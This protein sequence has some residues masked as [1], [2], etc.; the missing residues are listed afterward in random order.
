MSAVRVRTNPDAPT[1]EIEVLADYLV[2]EPRSAARALALP[3][4]SAS[5][6]PT[7]PTIPPL[8]AA[9]ANAPARWQ[10]ELDR[11]TREHSE[12]RAHAAELEIVLARRS[13]E[14]LEA[15][16]REAVLVRRF[17]LQT[18]RIAD[19]DR[20][21]REQKTLIEQLQ[22]ALPKRPSEASE[23]L[24]IRGIGPKYARNLSA[25][26]VSTIEALAALTDDD[27][28]RIEQQLRIR[29]GRIRRE[30][31]VEQAQE[32]AVTRASI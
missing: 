6:Q 24:S 26:G 14:L 13:Q 3:K 4:P 19:L 20:Q 31:W 7:T 10:V 15:D 22:A 27:V 25:L 8:P 23:L 29:N 12:T 21:V 18:L 11:V 17:H 30:R 9:T 5:P 32:H 16:Q 2:E 1:E 28:S